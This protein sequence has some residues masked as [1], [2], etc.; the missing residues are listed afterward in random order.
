[1]KDMKQLTTNRYKAVSYT[2]RLCRPL[3]YKETPENSYNRNFPE[4][5]YSI[6]IRPFCIETD[7]PLAYEW[8][9]RT[10]EPHYWKMSGPAKQLEDTYRLMLEA[11]FAQPFIVL[12]NNQPVCLLDIYQGLY[13]EL[14]LY[15]NMQPDD[16]AIQYLLAPHKKTDKALAACIME[17]CLHYFFSFREVKRIISDPHIFDTMMNEVVRQTGFRLITKLD[18]PYKRAYLYFCTPNSFCLNPLLTQKH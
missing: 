18:T 10:Y 6:S 4:Y 3:G 14:S 9:S 1:M 12:L 17:T 16:Y 8:V 5:G 7:F 2:S 13:H 15:Y 11:D